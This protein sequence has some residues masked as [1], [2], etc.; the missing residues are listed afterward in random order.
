MIFQYHFLNSGGESDSSSADD[1][2][3]V[4]SADTGTK[5]FNNG[6][7]INKI[8]TLNKIFRNILFYM[9]ANN[10]NTKCAE[11]QMDKIRL[12]NFSKI[13]EDREVLQDMLLTETSSDDDDDEWNIEKVKTLIK[14]RKYTLKHRKKVL[15]ENV[16][17]VMIYY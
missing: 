11:R 7:S 6:L 5:T 14:I 13:D 17:N 15:S 4:E 12:Y 3:S 1:L 2:C 16:K 8:G 10:C 9:N